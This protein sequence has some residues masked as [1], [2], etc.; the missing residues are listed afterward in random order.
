LTEASVLINEEARIIDN[1]NKIKDRVSS[2]MLRAGRSPEQ[3]PVHIMAVTKTVPAEKINLCISRGITLLG[4]NRVQEF[5]EKRALYEK[6]RQFISL[7]ACKKTK[8]SI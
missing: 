2:A 3:D 4:E 5:L 7:E 1:I 8:L 6:T